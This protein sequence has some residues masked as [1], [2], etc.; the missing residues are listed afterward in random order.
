MIGNSTHSI[1][2]PSPHG[3]GTLMTMLTWNTVLS[4]A[5]TPFLAM[6][7]PVLIGTETTLIAWLLP[8]N[9]VTQST[10]RVQFPQ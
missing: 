5:T 8:T 6:N 10:Y 4:Q 7:F 3:K 2:T 1:W 9:A